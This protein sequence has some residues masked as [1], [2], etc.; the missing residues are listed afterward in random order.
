MSNLAIRLGIEVLRSVA[1]T[2][3]SSTY[4]GIGTPILYP[5]RQFYIVNTT[6]TLVIISDDGIN[7]KFVIP[8]GSYI[9]DDVASN[10]TAPGESLSMAQGTRLYVRTTGSPSSGSVYF[11]SFYAAGVLS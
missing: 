11:T 6:N 2:S 7:D 9:L 5:C 8:A 1:Y 3:L 10:R 4:M